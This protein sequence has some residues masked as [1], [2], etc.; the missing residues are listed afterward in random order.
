METITSLITFIIGLKLSSWIAQES[1]DDSVTNNLLIL[2][3]QVLCPGNYDEND[4]TNKILYKKQNWMM[5][6]QLMAPSSCITKIWRKPK[7]ICGEWR[8]EW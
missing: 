5:V 2:E 3:S 6:I 1:N 4:K 8:W 7:I